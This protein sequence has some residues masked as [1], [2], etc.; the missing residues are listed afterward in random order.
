MMSI[1][2]NFLV[3][4]A[5]SVALGVFVAELVTYYAARREW[6]AK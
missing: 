6:G 3:L 4:G 5:F 1:A 2:I